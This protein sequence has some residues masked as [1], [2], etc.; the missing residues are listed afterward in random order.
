[1]PDLSDRSGDEEENF[2]IKAGVAN[3]TE[4]HKSRPKPKWIG[5]SISKF[6]DVYYYL[7][8]VNCSQLQYWPKVW[9]N[10]ININQNQ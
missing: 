3:Q 6:D 1:M 5:S 10:P 7:E 4:D 2:D 8:K 9:G